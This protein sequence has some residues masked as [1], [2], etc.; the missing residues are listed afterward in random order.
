L[1]GIWQPVVPPTLNKKYYLFHQHNFISKQGILM[2]EN[3]GTSGTTILL[4][5]IIGYMF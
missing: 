5:Y 1:F 2:K 4:Y 3:S